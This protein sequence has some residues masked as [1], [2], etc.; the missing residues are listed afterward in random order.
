MPLGPSQS[1]PYGALSMDISAHSHIMLVLVL[2]D[3]ADF[4]RS[5]GRDPEPTLPGGQGQPPEARSK[6]LAMNTKLV[7]T[8]GYQHVVRKLEFYIAHVLATPSEIMEGVSEEVLRWSKKVQEEGQNVVGSISGRVE[9]VRKPL[10]Q[11]LIQE[12]G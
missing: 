11:Q 9:A 8:H 10:K 7:G 5:E 2:S 3:M 6:K 4:F 12:I 1:V